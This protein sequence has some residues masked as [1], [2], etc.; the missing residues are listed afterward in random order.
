MEAITI[1]DIVPYYLALLGLLLIWELYRIEVLVG[2][3]K[4]VELWD[5]PGIKLFLHAGPEDSHTCPACQEANNTVFLPKVVASKKFSPLAKPCTNPNGCRCLMVGLYGSWPEALRLQWQL[6]TQAGRIR[7]SSQEMTQLLDEALARR[8]AAVTEDRISIAVLEAFRAEGSNPDVAVERYRFVVDHALA[9]RDLAFVVPA[10][11][12]LSDL[13]E[14]LGRKDEAL[15]VADQFLKAYG[16]KK[17]QPHGPTDE[18]LSL[19]SQ[20]MTPLQM[21]AK[22]S[23]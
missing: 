23:I 14:Q 17:A 20:R 11:L 15:A 2:R 10:Y 7:L 12:R 16:E 13:L 3:I 19:I 21:S 18:Q 22:R 4:A 5:W 1:P 8:G 6:G 9:D